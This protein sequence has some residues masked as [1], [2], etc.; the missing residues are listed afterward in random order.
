MQPNQ[1]T[2]VPETRK[3]RPEAAPLAAE[4][5]LYFQNSK[6]EGVVVTRVPG[7]YCVWF[8]QVKFDR[9]ISAY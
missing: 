7:E 8:Q 3:A 5:S 4:F 9:V 6:L 1:T 2:L